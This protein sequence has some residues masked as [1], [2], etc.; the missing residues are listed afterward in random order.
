LYR[1]ASLFARLVTLDEDQASK[2]RKALLQSAEEFIYRSGLMPSKKQIE[3]QVRTIIEDF[4]G[5]AGV[6]F[7]S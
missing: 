2:V 5:P 1:D 7:T 3:D 6:K 4:G